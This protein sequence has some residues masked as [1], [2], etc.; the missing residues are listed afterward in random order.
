MA[1]SFAA[2]RQGV[3]LYRRA[4]SKY[5]SFVKLAL[6]VLDPHL[7]G[8]E[9]FSTVRAS[10]LGGLKVCLRVGRVG[11]AG[12]MPQMSLRMCWENTYARCGTAPEFCPCKD[13]SSDAWFA[14]DSQAK[15]H[16]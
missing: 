1:C 3:L 9:V 5:H 6:H 13:L 8:F 15:D 11:L 4:C 10:S 2:I 7:A 12:E 16:S 14:V